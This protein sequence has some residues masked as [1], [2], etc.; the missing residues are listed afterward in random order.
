M[1]L[2]IKNET[3]GELL[4]AGIHPVGWIAREITT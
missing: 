1:Q 4:P 3:V 2:E